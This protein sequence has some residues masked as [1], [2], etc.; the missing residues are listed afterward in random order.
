MSIADPGPGEGSRVPVALRR[1]GLAIA[2]S[3]A[4]LPIVALFTEQDVTVSPLLVGLSALM[5]GLARGIERDRGR[6]EDGE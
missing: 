2:L 3:Q 6:R 4:A 1:G 5:M